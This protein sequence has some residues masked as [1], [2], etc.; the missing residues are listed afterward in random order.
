MV[1]VLLQAHRVRRL[2][3]LE[4]FR[5]VDLVRAQDGAHLVVQ[6]LGRRAGQAGEPGIPQPGQVVVERQAQ[7]VGAG[8]D[9]QRREG[10]HVHVRCRRLHRLDD[11]EIGVAGVAGLDAALQ[12]HL[13]GAARP[14]F[15][16]AR[17]DLGHVEIVGLVAMA[18]VVPALGE[19]AE[20]AAVGAD[21]GVV[22]VAIDDVGHGVADAL[23]AQCVGRPA[24]GGEVRAARVEQRDDVGL[25]QADALCD[26]RQHPRD[27]RRRPRIVAAR[28]RHLRGRQRLE[29]ARR[30]PVLPR[31]TRPIH[32]PQG[33]RDQRR[34]EP[35]ASG[36][37]LP[38][39][40]RQARLPLEGRGRRAIT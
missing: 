17:R 22:D 19:G 15:R 20:L 29:P 25:V 39:R 11:G 13:G 38:Q 14:G 34:I 21:V 35:A 28:A 23:G 36:C 26:A 4:P 16:R 18:E 27:R 24:D 3:H 12:A 32:V 1:A 30:P 31:Q 7:R 5:R 2:H 10:M 8:A 6:D 40:A 9:L 37:R 33:G